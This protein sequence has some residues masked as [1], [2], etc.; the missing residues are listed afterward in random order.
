MNRVRG[1][2]DDTVAL[3]RRDRPWLDTY[4][5]VLVGSFE[6]PSTDDLRTAVAALAKRYPASRLTWRPDDA[7]RYWIT[8][9]PAESIVVER[10]WDDA[11][12][13]GDRVADLAGDPTLEPPLS[14]IRYPRH[15]G[16]RMSHGVG[17]GRLFLT[18]IAAAL[19]TAITGEVVQWPVQSAGR[20]PLASA[21]FN[22]FG[23]RPALA[24]AAIA[25]RPDHDG[26]TNPPGEQR[27]WSPSR[28][29]QH[30][31]MPREQA[32]EM[33]AWG[34][35]N[36]PR[37]SR[38]ALQVSLYLKALHK[39]GLEIAP[40]VRVIVDLRR[41]LG[42]KYIDGNFVAGVPMLLDWTMGPEEISVRIKSTSASGR[43]LAGQMLAALLGGVSMP[44][45]TSVDTAARPRMTFSNLGWSPEIDSL[46]FLPDEPP[47][48]AGSVPPEGP[49]G[50]TVLCGD[51]RRVMAMDTT[52]HDNAVNPV[53]LRE[54]MGL[55]LADPIG[56]LSDSRGARLG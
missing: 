42:W 36:T 15:I 40:D 23:R 30:T 54:A 14:L 38:F 33:Y 7:R 46:P 9:R 3:Q 12:D 25:D 19:Q 37:A 28:S 29:V 45:A 6:M 31:N 5:T 41:Y 34:K 13:V 20:F 21:A 44:E 51:N 55:A 18:V 10:D 47:V 32:D 2:S 35:R 8:D 50:M 22:T 43:P 39:A 27:P 52:F 48:Y 24:L 26:A 4:V 53:M 16:L 17:D 56:L 1:R 11:T 49:L